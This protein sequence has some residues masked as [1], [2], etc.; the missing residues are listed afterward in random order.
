MKKFWKILIAFLVLLITPILVFSIM[1]SIKCS[2]DESV[3]PVSLP[4]AEAVVKHIEKYGV[5][6]NLTQIENSP[7]VLI[8]CSQK[9]DNFECRQ[10]Y[11][12][13]EEKFYSASLIKPS[14][15]TNTSYI[16]LLIQHNFTTNYYDL[17]IAGE[18]SKTYDQPRVNRRPIGICH[19]FKQ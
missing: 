2:P 1:V 18:L 3:Y 11:F 19:Q 10:F 13:Y 6:E 4:L 8:P 12:K 17:F 7:Y 5:P 9:T 15:E 14:P 16:D